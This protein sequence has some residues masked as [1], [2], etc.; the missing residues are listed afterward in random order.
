VV[1]QKLWKPLPRFIFR[2]KNIL[3]EL[4]KLEKVNSFIDVG[5]GSGGLACEIVKN[6]GLNG[7][8]YDF[9]KDAISNANALQKSYNIR[10][11][12]LSFNVSDWTQK[13]INKTDLIFC[14]EV[15]EHVKDDDKLFDKLVQQSNKYLIISVPSKR[16][17]YS[18]SD[19]LAG[20]YRRYD[21]KDLMKLIEHK[22]IKAKKIIGYGYP[23]TNLV[24]LVREKM[25]S[26]AKKKNTQSTKKL[27]QQSGI[28]V[29]KERPIFSKLPMNTL[30]TPFYWI[31]LL[32]NHTD[33]SEG[34]LVILDKK[35][36]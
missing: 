24:R 35:L 13:K 20:H 33:L 21:K 18:H 8:G 22:D 15:L 14:C 34:Y 9:S 7:E 2:K 27:T 6:T 36:D 25:S 5:G 16:R 23:F 11:N 17:L 1:D 10:K 3:R 29:V 26:D 12:K 4:K 31:S 28:R 30:I 19:E 32:F